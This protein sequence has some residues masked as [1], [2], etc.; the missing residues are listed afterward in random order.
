MSKYVVAPRKQ[1]LGVTKMFGRG[2]VQVPKEARRILGLRDG[3]RVLWI[4][5]SDREVIVRRADDI[6]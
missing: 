4:Q 2:R 5:A 6:A 3:D 1:V